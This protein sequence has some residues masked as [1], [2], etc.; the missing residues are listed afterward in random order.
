MAVRP[1]NPRTIA[2]ERGAA[3]VEFA[4]VLPILVAILFGTLE[5]GKLF[6]YWIDETHLANEAAR[7]A[8]VN[9][10]P[11]GGNLQQYIRGQADSAELRT[12]AHVCIS[13]PSGTMN[14]GDPVKVDMT[15]N[16]GVPIVRGVLNGF[17]GGTLPST[18]KITG[19]SVMRLEAPP[20]NY[21]AGD[22]GTGAC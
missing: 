15:Y 17:F 2:G 14:V 19:T 13:F 5:F 10:V 18:I 8:A 9:N 12:G 4:L 20:T 6:N 3:L 11:G 16:A 21:T 22:G 7:W 1:R